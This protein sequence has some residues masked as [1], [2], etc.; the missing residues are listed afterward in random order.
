MPVSPHD[1]LAHAV[2]LERRDAAV[3]HQLDS[4]H[5]LGERVS[6]L[7]HR[8]A[9]VRAALE[10]IPLAV[11]ELVSRLVEA[12][13]EAARARSAL[14]AA[15]ARL[16]ELESARRRRADDVER[17]RSEV[18]TARDDLADTT[19]EIARLKAREAE[20]HAEETALADEDEALIQAARVAA[21]ELRDIPRVASGAGE[22]PDASLEEWASQ[23][24]SALFVARGLLEQERERIV[25]EANA[26]GSAVL[27]EPL[28]GSSVALVR[29]R[30]E[31]RI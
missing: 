25:Q 17:A 5:M 12:K 1:V 21:S 23:A 8:A 20:L 10:R 13:I 15:E 4:L 27:G 19:R 3:A 18:G 9:E 24:R 2:E 16:A 30:L 31:E 6:E 28:G 7:R 11:E 22:D 26:L 14:E 29:R